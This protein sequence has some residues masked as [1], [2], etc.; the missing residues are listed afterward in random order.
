[1]ENK[2]Y[3]SFNSATRSLS[4]AIIRQTPRLKLFGTNNTPFV[5]Y[6]NV[7][8]ATL[9][10]ANKIYEC[11][12][13]QTWIYFTIDSWEVFSLRNF[14]TLRFPAALDTL[15]QHGGSAYT[16]QYP[17]TRQTLIWFKRSTRYRNKVYILQDRLRCAWRDRTTLQLNLMPSLVDIRNELK[18]LLSA[19]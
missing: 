3:F 19:H 4:C 17:C 8:Q 16:Y 9:A 11:Y 13:S 14:R 18:E 2:I 12:F 10:Q 5:Y 6:R 15:N 1:M 7:I